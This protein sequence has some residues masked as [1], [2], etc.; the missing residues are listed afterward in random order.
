M[1]GLQTTL[2]TRV[3][4][5]SRCKTRRSC[6]SSKTFLTEIGTLS[7]RFSST[8]PIFTKINSTFVHS[9]WQHLISFSA[10]TR[11]Q[12]SQS[13]LHR[14]TFSK[15]AVATLKVYRRKTFPTVAILSICDSWHQWNNFDVWLFHFNSIELAMRN[16]HLISIAILAS[17]LLLAAEGSKY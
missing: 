9:K 1:V 10:G 4:S 17:C 8:Q 5:A 13:A 2:S 14:A 12:N 15:V 3:A 11:H 16:Q 6:N 7:T